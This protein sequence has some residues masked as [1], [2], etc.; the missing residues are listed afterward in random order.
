MDQYLWTVS[1]NA[2]ISLACL[3]SMS[4]TVMRNLHLLKLVCPKDSYPSLASEARE[5]IGKK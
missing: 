3:V 5:L 1:Q 2:L 4:P